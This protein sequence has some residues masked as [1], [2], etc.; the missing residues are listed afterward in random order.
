VVD[1]L[2]ALAVQPLLMLGHVSY[3]DSADMHFL[4]GVLLCP[5]RTCRMRRLSLAPPG[6]RLSCDCTA[7][8]SLDEFHCLICGYDFEDDLPIMLLAGVQC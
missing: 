5:S 3:R 4:V 8:N 6:Y 2:K 7:V 1:I